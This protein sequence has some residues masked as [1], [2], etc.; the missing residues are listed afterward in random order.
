MTPPHL[1]VIIIT[2]A[3]LQDKNTPPSPEITKTAT[4]LL[5][6][7]LIENK[8]VIYLDELPQNLLTMSDGSLVIK[9]PLV[10]AKFA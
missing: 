9:K 8:I 4:E 5:T 2:M 10:R 6:D 3:A 1:S 7:F